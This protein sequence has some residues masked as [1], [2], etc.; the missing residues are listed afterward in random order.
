MDVTI[1]IVSY[2]CYS[3]LRDCLLTVLAQDIVAEVI[4]VDN[5]SVDETRQNIGEEFPSVRLI[6]QADNLGFGAASNLGYRMSSSP[7]VLFLNPD[8]RLEDPTLIRRGVELIRAHSEIGILG[9]RLLKEDGTLDH[10]CKRG[11]PTPVRA[12]CY[13]LRLHRLFPRAPVLAGYVAGSHDELDAGP[14]DV[15]NGAFMLAR[16]EVIDFIGGPFDERFWMYAEDIDACR[17]ARNAG[18]I[19]WYEPS[20]RLVHSK[21][22]TDSG[23]RSTRTKLAFYESMN[24]YYEK[25]YPSKFRHPLAAVARVA[26]KLAILKVQVLNR[27]TP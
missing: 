6:P 17:R 8:T 7:F 3:L 21:G 18:F 4:V 13:Y 16:R 2:N 10:A 5:A 26:A 27:E 20:M 12:L 19:V 22:A 15:V 25:W 14:V 23:R 1:I 9:G 11:E 24:L